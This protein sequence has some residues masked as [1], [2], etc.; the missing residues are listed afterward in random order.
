M[1]NPIEFLLKKE[2]NQRLVLKHGVIL[3]HEST[4]GVMRSCVSWIPTSELVSEQEYRYP[5][6]DEERGR[7]VITMQPS[8]WIAQVGAIG[9][10]ALDRSVRDPAY[11][12]NSNAFRRDEVATDYQPPR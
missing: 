1:Y 12:S 11:R 7:D 5:G 6:T 4:R 8:E 2:P 9:K 3:D 10:S